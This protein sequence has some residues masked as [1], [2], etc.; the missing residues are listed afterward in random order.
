MLYSEPEMLNT[1][2]V[3]RLNFIPMFD[4]RPVAY[5]IGLLTLILGCTMLL[6][7]AIDLYDDNG[8]SWVFVLST[9]IT[10]LTG[11]VIAL[12]C[13]NIS[14]QGLTLQQTF[15]LTTCVW[16]ILPIFAAIPFIIGSTDLCFI[17]AFFEAMSG[18][19]TTGSTV[20]SEL[21]NQPRGLLLWRGLMQWFG[22]I[23]IIVVAMVFLPLLRVGGM[24]IFR[25]E[26]FDT[27]GKI[28]PRAVEIS[29]SI[30]AVYVALTMI[31]TLAYTLAGLTLFD[32]LVH[33]MTT[34]STGGFSNYDNSFGSFSAGAE[35][36]A[37]I[38]M[39][40]AAL[41]FIRYVQ[42][43]RGKIRPIVWDS[44]VISF[45]TIAIVS[46]IALFLWLSL[47]LSE[48][49]E[50]GMRKAAFNGVS[51]LTG[52]GFS[53]DDYNRWGG[54]PTIIFFLIGLIGGCAGS[55]SCSIKVFRFQLL[56]A[57]IRTQIQRLHSPNGIFF[58]KYQRCLVSYDVISSVMVF[59]ILFFLSIAV[60]SVA[61]S[62]TGLDFITSVSGASTAL[63]NIGPG[64]GEQIGPAGNFSEL[65]NTAKW[66]LVIGMLLGRLELMAVFVLFNVN[67]WRV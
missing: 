33:A 35:Y 36:V 42:L 67:F 31:C 16:V 60:L 40:L 4:V 43:L 62:M 45:F 38:F 28:L 20:L 50:N 2:L 48:T 46:V 12:A 64:L 52:T 7:A 24:Q 29:R 26:G 37:I 13:A 15:L 21:E 54:F 25:S 19:T 9:I 22:G 18:L 30:S 59:F 5:V 34:I 11:G 14:G 10:C 39:L 49:L 27:F 51:V 66:L 53:S 44:Q 6:P 17:D 32:A 58:L 1:A 61:L 3:R 56:F 41:P 57:S 55:T 47:S 65:N 63:A 8:Q 23:G